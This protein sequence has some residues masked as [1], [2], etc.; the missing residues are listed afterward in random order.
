[1]DIAG[2][3]NDNEPIKAVS[4]I[5]QQGIAVLEDI[6]AVQRDRTQEEKSGEDEE[7]ESQGVSMSGLLNALDGIVS[8]DGQAF[9]MTTNHPEKLDPALVRP[10]RADVRVEMTAMSAEVLSQMFAHFYPE[11]TATPTVAGLSPAECQGVFLRFPDDPDRA[12]RE[13]EVLAKQV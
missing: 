1:M 6:D 9:F 2:M 12:M 13:L 11:S 4:L 10:G 7:A 5:P 8:F 3:G